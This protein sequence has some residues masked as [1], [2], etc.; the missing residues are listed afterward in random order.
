MV[1][2]HTSV[3]VAHILPR[4]FFWERTILYHNHTGLF[5]RKC[6][7]IAHLGTEVDFGAPSVPLSRSRY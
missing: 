4:S 3:S 5:M 1:S 2:S 7:C 6:Y